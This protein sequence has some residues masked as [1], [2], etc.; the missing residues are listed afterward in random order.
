MRRKRGKKIFAF[1]YR[2]FLTLAIVQPPRD[3]RDVIS[4]DK[5][6]LAP[7]LVF[8]PTH[9]PPCRDAFLLLLT[10]LPIPGTLKIFKECGD[11]GGG[12]GRKGVCV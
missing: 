9:L 3:C 11:S 8:L 2:D 4:V 12:M 7:T 10:S 1:I 6:T 5:R